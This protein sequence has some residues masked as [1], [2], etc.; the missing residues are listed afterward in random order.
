MN[1]SPSIQPTA[2]ATRPSTIYCLHHSGCSDNCTSS[3]VQSEHRLVQ[4]HHAQ[5]IG[6]GSHSHRSTLGGELRWANARVVYATHCKL[7][8]GTY[9]S[10]HGC[11]VAPRCRLKCARAPAATSQIQ[12]RI[13][14]SPGIEMA[15][16]GNNITLSFLL[17][18]KLDVFLYSKVYLFWL[19]FAIIKK[20]FFVSL[21]FRC[22]STSFS[23]TLCDIHCHTVYVIDNCPH[24]WKRSCTQTFTFSRSRK[25][26]C[27]QIQNWLTLHGVVLCAG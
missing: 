21:H 5:P 17:V 23:N 7:C 24:T 2:R 25:L 11:L 19:T 13:S 20:Y 18:S 10:S 1:P 12:T 3:K 8:H 22:H 14:Y 16:A 4:H 6:V 15:H 26:K 27:L 9:H